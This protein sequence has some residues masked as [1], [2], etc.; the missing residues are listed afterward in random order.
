[1]NLE[2]LQRIPKFLLFSAG[3]ATLSIVGFVDYITGT[4]LSILVFYLVPIF[5]ITYLIGKKEGLLTVLVSTIIWATADQLGSHV[6]THPF[7]FYWNVTVR[8]IFFATGYFFA[9][10]KTSLDVEKSLSRTDDLTE[11]ANR[12]HFITQAEIVL[13]RC[14]QHRTPFTLAYIDIDNFKLVNDTFGHHVGDIVLMNTA[15]TMISHIRKTDCVSRL[16]GDE[17]AVLLPECNAGQAREIIKSLQ[18]GLM[19]VVKK[20]NWPISFS[21][22]VVTFINSPGSVDEMIKIVDHLMYTVKNNGKNGVRHELY[23][24][25]P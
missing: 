8:L 4:E 12:R 14:N 13:A 7:Y 6:Y 17:F 24:V 15:K 11:I 9:T 2:K 22:G 16:G 21:I 19:N 25:Q 18:R 20:H 3:I 23:P 5:F 1:M 10:V